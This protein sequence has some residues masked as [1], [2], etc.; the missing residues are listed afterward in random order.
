MIDFDVVT[1]PSP[2]EKPHESGPKPAA[3]PPGGQGG[4]GAE[5]PGSENTQPGTRSSPDSAPGNKDGG[6]LMPGIDLTNS[7]TLQ[8]MDDLE[9]VRQMKRLE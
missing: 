2:A 7:L 3:R 1:G 9:H 5:L 8:E 4:S 6:G